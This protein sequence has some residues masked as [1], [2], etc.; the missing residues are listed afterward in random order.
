[1]ARAWPDAGRYSAIAVGEVAGPSPRSNSVFGRQPT[2]RRSGRQRVS[3]PHQVP[4]HSPS[5]RRGPVRRGGFLE[6]GFDRAWRG[7]AQTI[8]IVGKSGGAHRVGSRR[9]L[10]GLAPCASTAPHRRQPLT[11]TLS[12]GGRGSKERRTGGAFK[13]RQWLIIQGR[14]EGNA[15]FPFAPVSVAPRLAVLQQPQPLGCFSR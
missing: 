11:P 1:M 8:S 12:P 5:G 10:K 7:R 6:L 9:A 13:P 15:L 2:H 4:W 3:S 14:L